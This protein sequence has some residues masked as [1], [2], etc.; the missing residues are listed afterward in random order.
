MRQPQKEGKTEMIPALFKKRD[1]MRKKFTALQHFYT[2]FL[3]LLTHITKEKKI[4]T[5][6]TPSP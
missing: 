6:Q 3:L 5:L 1:P 2:H 4:L